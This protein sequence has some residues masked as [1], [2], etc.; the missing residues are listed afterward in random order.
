MFKLTADA[1]SLET[2]YFK[3]FCVCVIVEGFFCQTTTSEERDLGWGALGQTELVG[4]GVEKNSFTVDDNAAHY[5]SQSA[6]ESE[7]DF[8]R[9]VSYGSVLSSKKPLCSLSAEQRKGCNVVFE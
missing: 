2:N 5:F 3:W 6:H 8:A 4:Q 9:Y 1:A 7:E